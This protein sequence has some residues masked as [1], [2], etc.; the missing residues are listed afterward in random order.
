MSLLSQLA[1]VVKN[2][3]ANARICKRRGLGV[4]IRKITWRSAWQSIPVFCL[5]NPMDREAWGAEVY[6]ITKSCT[7][8]SK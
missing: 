5:E 4:W 8:L 2:S 1:L 3:P 6:R 7:P